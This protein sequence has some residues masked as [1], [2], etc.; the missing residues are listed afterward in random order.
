M[1]TTINKHSSLSQH[2][3]SSLIKYSENKNDKNCTKINKSQTFTEQECL[4]TICTYMLLAG[5][6]W[7]TKI[8]SINSR[9]FQYFITVD[10]T[11]TEPCQNFLA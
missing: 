6:C 8:R 9:D 2:F 4:N 5:Y 7:V 11:N 1:T 3:T 10:L